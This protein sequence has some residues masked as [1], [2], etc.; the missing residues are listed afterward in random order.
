MPKQTPESSITIKGAFEIEYEVSANLPYFEGHFPEMPVLPA[1]AVI[2]ASLLA[3]ARAGE[4]P[5]ELETLTSAKFTGFI[6]P[7]SKVRIRFTREGDGPGNHWRV[8][9]K[10][11]GEAGESLAEL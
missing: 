2:D 1:M 9:W 6:R 11:A 4:A 3:I 10:N 7:G 5:V 8:R